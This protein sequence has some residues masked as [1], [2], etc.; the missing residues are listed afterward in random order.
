MGYKRKILKLLPKAVQVNIEDYVRRKRNIRKF[1]P[2]QYLN[3]Q[4]HSSIAALDYYQ[5]IFVHIPKNAGLSV[6]YTLFGNTGGSHRKI[7]SYKDLFAPKTF[8]KYFKFTFVRNPWDRLVSTYFFLKKGGVTEKDRI[9]AEKNIMHY[10]SFEDFVKQWL[11]I[12][13]I[14]N[15]LHF[16]PQYSF[17]ENKFGEIDMD[18]IGRFENLDNDFMYVA[19]KL[20]INRKLK[21]TNKSIRNKNYKSYYSRETKEIVNKVYQK[22]IC[23]F[24]YTF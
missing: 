8:K 10:E 16:Q 6:C 11:T 4:F 21:K 1:K 3:P 9:W 17:I 24:K 23:L 18:F 14:H 13:N 19:S 5:C 2:D 12:E 7:K 20:G 15:S 22:D